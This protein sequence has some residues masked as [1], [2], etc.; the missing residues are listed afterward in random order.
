MAAMVPQRRNKM[1]KLQKITETEKK[2]ELTDTQKQMVAQKP[3][4]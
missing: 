2:A 4:L 1:K 3:E